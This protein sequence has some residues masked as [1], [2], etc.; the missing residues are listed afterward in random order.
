[1][2]LEKVHY[3][4]DN[5][6]IQAV[7]EE[8]SKKTKTSIAPSHPETAAAVAGPVEES[9]TPAIPTQM[10]SVKWDNSNP[11]WYEEFQF[12]IPEEE[13]SLLP[14]YELFLTAKHF[15][16]LG[17]PSDPSI[18]VIALALFR[19]QLKHIYTIRFNQPEGWGVVE[20]EF[21]VCI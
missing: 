8:K 19:D 14:S 20:M 6:S 5:T 12:Q 16:K 4:D 13:V 18:G 11:D 2:K 1:M 9:A 15:S 17:F 21:V 3:I 10:T 7:A